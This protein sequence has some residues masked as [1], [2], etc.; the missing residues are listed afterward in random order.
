MKIYRKSLAICN[1][2]YWVRNP[3]PVEFLGL[4][5]LDLTARR[6]IEVGSLVGDVD[7]DL[8]NALQ[9]SWNYT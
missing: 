4:G 8:F 9:R 2:G 3:A 7:L 6:I 5:H 1:T